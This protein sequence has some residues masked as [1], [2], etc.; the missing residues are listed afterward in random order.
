[1]HS[2]KVLNP[3]NVTQKWPEKSAL[4]LLY[5]FTVNWSS[6]ISTKRIHLGMSAWAR[7]TVGFT[8]VDQK[9]KFHWNYQMEHYIMARPSFN[10]ISSI[11]SIIKSQ[12]CMNIYSAS[13]TKQAF[14]CSISCFMLDRRMK[15]CHMRA[16]S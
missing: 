3:F 8:N 5:L 11:P 12:H 13:S 6:L 9:R 2:S 4:C 1:M 16:N 15:Q 10:R 7:A 14:F